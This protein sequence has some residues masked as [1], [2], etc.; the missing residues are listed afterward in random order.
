MRNKYKK[1]LRENRKE[2]LPCYRTNFLVNCDG[3]KL[4]ADGSLQI[5]E[6]TFS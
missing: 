6:L 3:D 4:V 5:K 2:N 1:C